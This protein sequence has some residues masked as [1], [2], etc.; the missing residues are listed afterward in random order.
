MEQSHHTQ[1][2][3]E[4]EILRVCMIGHPPYVVEKLDVARRIPETVIA[5][6]EKGALFCMLQKVQPQGNAA[7]QGVGL[8]P[9]PT[10]QDRLPD[11]REQALP[12]YEQEKREEP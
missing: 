6:T 10:E 11:A 12:E 4:L 5:V 8:E 9:A 3:K 1:V 7:A 2:E